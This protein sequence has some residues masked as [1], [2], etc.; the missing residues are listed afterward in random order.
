MA[1]NG[2]YRPYRHDLPRK[3]S[4]IR[5]SQLL[6][7]ENE[8]TDSPTA[9][10]VDSVRGDVEFRHLT[11][12]HPDAEYD[13]LSDVSFKINAGESIGVIGKTG[14]GKTT[15]ADLILRCYNVPRGCL[16][17][18]GKDVNDITISGLRRFCAYVPQDNYLFGDTIAN[19]IAFAS[20]NADMPSIIRS[21][22]LADVDDNIS[23]FSMG[24]D[25]LLG[26][27]A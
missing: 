12:R 25:T 14:C 15:V 26:N 13:A 2:Y 4:V 9:K 27:R 22:Q 3:A 18:D 7:T 1:D 20:D 24:Y 10:D 19:N 6:D 8:V 16:F 5:V 23:G 21:A 11:F 17:V